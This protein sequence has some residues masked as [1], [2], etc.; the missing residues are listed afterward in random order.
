MNELLYLYNILNKNVEKFEELGMPN[1][2]KQ[3][4]NC[5]KIIESM[6]NNYNK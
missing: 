4:Y 1:A 3:N 5:L 6:I 2:S